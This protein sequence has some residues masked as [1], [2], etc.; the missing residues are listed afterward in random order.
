MKMTLTQW[1][2][3][4]VSDIPHR[5]CEWDTSQTP[6]IFFQYS[7]TSVCVYTCLCSCRFIYIDIYI[8]AHT[9]TVYICICEYMYL[10]HHVHAET[11][12]DSQMYIFAHMSILCDISS[13]HTHTHL[14]LACL[15]CLI[16]HPH[17]LID[18]RLISMSD[19]SFTHT[20]THMDDLIV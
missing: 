18:I 14:S 3:G 9:S 15:D 10:S 2:M 4:E 19:I 8:H 6:V 5:I 20:H 1:S 13:T 11:I 16:Y 7:H 12:A 17:T